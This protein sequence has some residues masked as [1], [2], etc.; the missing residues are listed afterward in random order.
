MKRLEDINIQPETII[1][2]NHTTGEDKEFVLR[3][4][5]RGDEQGIR[6]C[7]VDEYGNSYF[8]RGFYDL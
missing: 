1:L 3:L 8:K 6:Q 2:K 7:V 5:K 4:F